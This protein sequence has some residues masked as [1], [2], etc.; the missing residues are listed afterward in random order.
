MNFGP[1]TAINGCLI[2]RALGRKSAEETGP[3]WESAVKTQEECNGLF[4]RTQAALNLLGSC[5]KDPFGESCF[6]YLDL[7]TP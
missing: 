5:P 3:R 2:E 4:I 7:M 6:L 1:D